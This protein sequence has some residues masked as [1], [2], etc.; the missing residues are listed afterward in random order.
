MGCHFL[1]QGRFPTQGL[2]PH[3]LVDSLPLV[4]P[5][6]PEE[7]GEDDGK[8]SPWVRSSLPQ[9]YSLP[10]F[11]LVEPRGHLASAPWRLNYVAKRLKVKAFSGQFHICC[12]NYAGQLASLPHPQRLQSFKGRHWVWMGSFSYPLSWDLQEMNRPSPNTGCFG[13]SLS[14]KCEAC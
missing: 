2:N 5:G 8:E 11:A 13:S 1:L 9:G 4:P 3:L 6:K 10:F 14:I 7:P 12:V